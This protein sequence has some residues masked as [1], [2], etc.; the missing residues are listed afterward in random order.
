M[1]LKLMWA[2]LFLTA[3]LVVAISISGVFKE[4]STDKLEAIRSPVD[5]TLM[6]EPKLVTSNTWQFK[7]CTSTNTACGRLE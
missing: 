2:G 6:I 5:N 1:T 3:V 7:H 4:S